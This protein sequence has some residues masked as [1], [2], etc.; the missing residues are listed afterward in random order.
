MSLPDHYCPGC[1]VRRQAFLRYPWHFC[2]ACVAR[3]TDG[4]GQTLEFSNE[5]VSGGFMF[6]RAGE[7]DWTPCGSVI[8]IIQGRPVKV[9][10]AR[11]G[12]I[13]AEPLT[14]DPPGRAPHRQIDLTRP[15]PKT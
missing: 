4:A 13:V 1:G 9:H 5:S 14:Q 2:P 12:G 11:F 6:R 8:A 15:L 7:V 10:E 3:A